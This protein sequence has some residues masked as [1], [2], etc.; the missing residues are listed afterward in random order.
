[1][2]TCLYESVLQ[3]LPLPKNIFLIDITQAPENLVIRVN[4]TGNF[5]CRGNGPSTSWRINGTD[6]QP[7]SLPNSARG[8]W[9]Q[10]VITDPNI[11]HV[12]QVITARIQYNNTIVTCVTGN[13]FPFTESEEVT[14]R[15][16][17]THFEASAIE[18]NC[19][20]GL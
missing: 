11:T 5:T 12:L 10:R 14:L 13:Y 17:G 1:M 19:L 8:D 6:F 9:I 20:M 16:E 4:A 18:K 7:N 15:I 3:Q 2:Y